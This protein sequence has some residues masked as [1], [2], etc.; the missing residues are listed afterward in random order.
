VGNATKLTLP[1]GFALM[2]I[3]LNRSL[4]IKP[5]NRFCLPGEDHWN[6]WLRVINLTNRQTEGSLDRF[7]E[8]SSQF[9]ENWIVFTPLSS[10]PA[11]AGNEITVS[12]FYDWKEKMFMTPGLPVVPATFDGT[13]ANRIVDFTATFKDREIIAV[14]DYS[15]LKY[16]GFKA[17]AVK[18][19]NI[20]S[21]L[22]PGSS[23][24]I[25]SEEDE[26]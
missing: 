23:T 12:L 1:D 17:P 3:S 11:E 26:Q 22:T 8:V 7:N 6:K 13:Y 16:V 4:G 18:G 20:C 15:Q 5:M 25:I 10:L 14:K 21:K 2:D 9:L 24:R 19:S